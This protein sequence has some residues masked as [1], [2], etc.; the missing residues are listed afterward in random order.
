MQSYSQFF[1][2]LSQDKPERIE[3]LQ[4]SIFQYLFSLEKG[5]EFFFQCFYLLY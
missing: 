1:S 5:E 2:Q 3:L 4:S